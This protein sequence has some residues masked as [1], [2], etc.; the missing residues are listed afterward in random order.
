MGMTAKRLPKNPGPSWGYRFMRMVDRHTP[1]P[2]MNGLLAMG[3]L[4]GLIRLPRQRRHSRAFL[5]LALGRPSTFNDT[6]KHFTEFSKFLVTRFRAADGVQPNFVPSDQS[7]DRIESLANKG[8]QALYGT[9][10]FGNSD[11]MGFW[12]SR[13][14][15]TIR[16]IR[17]QVGNSNDLEWLEKR[18]GNKVSFIWVNN[19]RNLLFQLKEA[20]SEGHSIAMKCDRIE[21]SSKAEAFEFL[22]ETRLFPFTIYHLAI[23]FNL[24][25]VFAFGLSTANGTIEVHSSPIYYPNAENK[26]TNL[27]NAKNHFQETLQLLEEL[28][29]R[30]PF[31]WSNFLDTTPKIE[32]SR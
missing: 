16:M 8:Q 4:Y 27:K 21:H 5:S 31:Q 28:I 23:L 11:L 15:L 7:T 24:P 2:I 29:R 20:V 19:P 9:F 26:R 32:T 12:L 25:V 30:E 1:Q 14:N 18:F 6:W 13:Y 22:G 3:S 17:H 10:H